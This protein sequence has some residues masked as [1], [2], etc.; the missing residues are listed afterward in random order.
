ME[1]PEEINETNT[2]SEELSTAPDNSNIPPLRELDNFLYTCTICGAQYLN[3]NSLDIHINA[4]H[5]KVRHCNICSRVFV[6][7]ENLA[8]HYCDDH[9]FFH[10]CTLCDS[11]YIN[12]S[13]L[14]IHYDIVHPF[15]KR[16]SLN[17]LM[18]IPSVPLTKTPLFS[19]ETLDKYANN[20]S[21]PNENT[22]ND[23]TAK[24]YRI[25]LPKEWFEKARSSS[26]SR[27]KEKQTFPGDIKKNCI[28]GNAESAITS[29]VMASNSCAHMEYGTELGQANQ[30]NVNCTV[31]HNCINNSTDNLISEPLQTI[32]L[33][34]HININGS[35]RS[36]TDSFTEPN[37]WIE[38]DIDTGVKYN[39][40][41]AGDDSF[42]VKSESDAQYSV[43]ADGVESSTDSVESSMAWMECSMDRVDRSMNEMENSMD[44]MEISI[45]DIESS[46]DGKESCNNNESVS[47]K[48]EDYKPD[49]QMDVHVISDSNHNL[50]QSLL[51]PHKHGTKY[52]VVTLLD[53]CKVN[54]FKIKLEGG[55]EVREVQ[56]ERC[57]L[58]DI[59]VVGEEVIQ[60]HQDIHL[61][62]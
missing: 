14:K 47:M 34:S 39:S 18:K 56:V 42:F 37:T 15:E 49:R 4:F 62:S 12:R 2:E 59:W 23:E 9:G 40:E 41:L 25:F 5:E 31:T 13:D 55:R 48:N 27:H 28:S 8:N 16:P 32:P 20:E 36:E 29:E 54:G 45:D 43:H 33:E 46:I 51:K 57:E 58:C 44:G 7:K 19:Q 22:F 35:E 6:S 61:Y 10:A 60:M 3:Q 38:T 24:S 17:H 53:I 50:H 21:T 30:S 11:Q 26:R 1:T 52:P